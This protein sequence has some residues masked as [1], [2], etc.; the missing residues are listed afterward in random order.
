MYI[1]LE[2]RNYIYICVP[3]SLAFTDLVVEGKWR[4]LQE[5]RENQQNV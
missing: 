3:I 4:V 1:I 5:A 2:G